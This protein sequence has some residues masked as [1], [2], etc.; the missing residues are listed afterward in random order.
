MIGKVSPKS[1]CGHKYMLVVIDYFTK[2]VE[3]ASYTRLI[4]AKVAKFIR[5]H[6]ICRYGVPYE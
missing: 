6:I 1:S 5:S 4:A 3:A 2:W